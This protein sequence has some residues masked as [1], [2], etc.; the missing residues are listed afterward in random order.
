M[1]PIPSFS[2]H[3][4]PRAP[5][6]KSRSPSHAIYVESRQSR[7]RVIFKTRRSESHGR[8]VRPQRSIRVTNRMTAIGFRHLLVHGRQLRPSQWGSNAP[9]LCTPPDRT[10]FI[11]WSCPRWASAHDRLLSRVASAPRMSHEQQKKKSLKVVQG[12]H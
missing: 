8:A 4:I 12:G 5:H 6:A 9:T 3:L 7:Y 2:P 1:T 10:R 11:C